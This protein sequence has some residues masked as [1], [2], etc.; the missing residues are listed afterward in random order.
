MAKSIVSLLVGCAITDGKIRSLDQPVSEFLPEL[1]SL[2]NRN[3]TIRTLL[4]MSASSDWEEAHS[5]L[6]TVTTEAYYGR[7]LWVL[8][9]RLKLK[10]EPGKFFEYQSGVTQLLAFVLQ[11]AVGESISAYASRRLWTPIQAEND[12]LWSLDYAGGM[13]K[14]YCCFNSDAR[15]FARLGLLVLNKGNWNGKQLISPDYLSDMVCADTTLLRADNG[16]KNNIYGFQF[17]ILKY[18]GYTIPYMRGILGQYV[19]IIP[20]LNAV[21]VRLGEKRSS[22]YSEP[23]HCPDDVYIWLDAAFDLLRK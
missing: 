12:A 6:F 15:D 5:S 18:K 14:A 1:N 22:A 13:E 10:S 9:N 2:S 7:N 23:N 21:V 11:R 8:M 3:L 17:W 4:T 16:T 19:F 20:Q